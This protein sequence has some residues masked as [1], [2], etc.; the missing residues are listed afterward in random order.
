MGNATD[1]PETDS[2]TS[3]RLSQDSQLG[4]EEEELLLGDEEEEEMEVEQGY[5]PAIKA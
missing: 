4:E 3:Y 2:D 5:V 1:F